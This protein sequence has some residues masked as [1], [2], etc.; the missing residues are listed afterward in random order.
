M[1]FL[2]QL[3]DPQR[4]AVTYTDGPLLIVAGPG[5]GKTR[6]LTYRIA[7]LME[8]G[9]DPFSI[10]ALTFTNKAAAE[11][12]HRIETI[13][14]NE[15]RNLFMGTF[16]SVF[17]RLLRVEGPRLGY[18]SNFTIYDTNDSKNVVKQ[19]IK[20]MGLNDKLYKP[21]SVFYRISGAKNNLIGPEQ[22]AANGELVAEDEEAGRPEIHKIFAAYAKKCKESGAMDFDDLLY[23]FYLILTKFPDAL[24]HYQH[25]FQHVLID[26]FQ[27][28]NIAQYE[29]IRKLSDV[30]QNV[31]VVGDDAQSIYAFR[32]ATI[33][34]ITNFQNDFPDHHTVKLEQNYRSTKMIVQAANHLIKNNTG[35]IP[36]EIWTSNTKGDKITLL[37]TSS[38]NEEGKLIAGLIF[39]LKNRQ[40]LTHDDFAILYRTNAQ[41]R[42]FEE[43]LRRMD[44]PYRI[45]GGLS[46]YQRK[47][48]KDLL[49]Y[50]KLLVNPNEEEALRRVINYPKRGIGMTSV[51][52]ISYIAQ[53]QGRTMW[54]VM[55]NITMYNLP[56]RTIRS[57]AD[58]MTM[59]KSFQGMLATKNAYDVAYQVAKTTNILGELYNDKSVEGVARYEN[60]Q[61]LLNG[62]KEFAA[63]DTLEEGQ[64]ELDTDRSL[65][66]YLQNITLLTGDEDEADDVDTVKLMTVHAAKGLEFPVVF[67]VGLEENLFP[68]AMSLYD[69]DDL[70][71]ERRLFYVAVTRAEQRLFLSY[72]DTR[73]KFGS[74]QYCSPSRFIEEVPQDVL[75]LPTSMRPK[76]HDEDDDGFSPVRPKQ[77]RAR[78]VRSGGQ[79]SDANFTP[80]DTSTLATGME[81]MHQRFGRGV[82]TDL[83]GDDPAKRIATIDFDRSGE[84][85]IMLKFAK[86]K[87]LTGD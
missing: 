41:S 22:Y 14:G 60:I 64:E 44:I 75:H 82:V 57:I 47:E 32:G 65:G 56:K 36:K 30:H 26:E 27:D 43:A 6:V 61:E 31:T 19:I 8:V 37:K 72:A 54:Q 71:E 15:A 79:P 38:D 12:R 18:P 24:H 85:K 81:V 49:G 9:A 45:Y 51:E 42:A 39:E 70:E 7:Y 13:V 48:V 16:H 77:R 34:N 55:D 29:I 78:R 1:N 33:A 35:Q 28:T 21:N 40:Q 63:Q 62:I 10:L 87:I 20:G 86:L 46:F 69:R 50:L 5:S 83:V 68:S 66:A 84:K 59:M 80:D 11:M 3:N 52:K 74:L 73:Y 67:V 17:A 53:Q 25:K 58:F 4:A 23:N 76:Q 2:D